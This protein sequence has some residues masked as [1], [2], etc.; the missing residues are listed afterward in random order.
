MIVLG[1]RDAFLHGVQVR[2]SVA[3]RIMAA[4]HCP[5]VSDFGMVLEQ[6]RGLLSSFH[7]R[8]RNKLQGGHSELITGTPSRGTQQPSAF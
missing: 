3:Y 7:G 1:V 8:L 4:S 2:T 5:V 6:A